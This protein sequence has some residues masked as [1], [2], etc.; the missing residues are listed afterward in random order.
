MSKSN[1]KR[2]CGKEAGACCQEARLLKYG[3]I[4]ILLTGSLIFFQFDIRKSFFQLITVNQ[5]KAEERMFGWIKNMLVQTALN[6][7]RE[8]MINPRLEGIGTVEQLTIKGKEIFLIIKLAGMENTPIDVT[9]SEIS[10]A[11]DGSSVTIGKFESNMPWVQ[12][13]L[14]MFMANRPMSIDDADVRK[15]AVVARKIFGL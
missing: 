14:D 3:L 5:A 2:E 7:V 10:I 4:F 9:G 6:K 12:N 8:K 13:A 11:E 1:D 15:A